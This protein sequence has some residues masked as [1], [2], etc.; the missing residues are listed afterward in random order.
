MRETLSKRQKGKAKKKVAVTRAGSKPVSK[1][2][3]ELKKKPVSSHTA[4]G[5]KQRKISTAKVARKVAKNSR[6]KKAVKNAQIKK[7]VKNAQIKK[8]VKNAQI[9]KAVKKATKTSLRRPAP[10]AASRPAKTR[11]KI[12]ARARK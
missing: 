12:I 4:S 10:N 11:K 3:K 2:K 8:L 1:K 7:A 6:I 5:L 9:K